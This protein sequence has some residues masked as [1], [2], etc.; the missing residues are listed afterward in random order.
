MDGGWLPAATVTRKDVPAVAPSPSSTCTVTTAL[1]DAPARGRKLMVR[2]APA[3]PKVMLLSGS[4]PWF[5][6]DTARRKRSGAD[7]ASPM[8]KGTSTIVP[9]AAT[10]WAGMVEIEGGVLRPWDS[11]RGAVTRKA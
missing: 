9:P 6:D 10:V 3:P 1:P 5:A 7:S 2:A 11:C 4:N 8:V